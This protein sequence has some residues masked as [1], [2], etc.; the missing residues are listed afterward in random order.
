MLQRKIL[1]LSNL[2][3]FESK[4]IFS[5]KIISKRKNN[6]CH[7]FMPGNFHVICGS[8]FG[9][10]RQSLAST[11]TLGWDV[12]GD[13]LIKKKWIELKKWVQKIFEWV[14][15]HSGCTPSPLFCFFRK[16]NLPFLFLSDVLFKWSLTK[17]H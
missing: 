11:E 6:H 5:Q 9:K 2:S 15:S 7:G 10:N 3:L 8:M 13:I 14:I 1:S 4:T 12:S 16:P 17:I